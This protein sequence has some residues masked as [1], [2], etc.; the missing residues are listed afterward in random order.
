[1]FILLYRC[2]AVPWVALCPGIEV[3]TLEYILKL[4]MKRNDWLLADMCLQAT[5]HRALF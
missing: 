2:L 4:K 3:I 1:M 5:N